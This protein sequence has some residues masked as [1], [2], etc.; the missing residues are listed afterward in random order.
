MEEY[1]SIC[2]ILVWVIT[3][4]LP[5]II[6]ETINIFR[7]KCHWSRE[8]GKR[9]LKIQV[10]KARPATFGATER[11]AMTGVGELE[12]KRKIIH[13]VLSFKTVHETFISHSSL[14]VAPS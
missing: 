8:K 2:F 4:E 3:T 11:K 10:T 14:V 9:I 7:I 5:S 12:S 13:Y 6:L 1:A